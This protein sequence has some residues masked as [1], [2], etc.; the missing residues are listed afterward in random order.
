[1]KELDAQLKQ[2]NEPA[3]LADWLEQ[4]GIESRWLIDGQLGGVMAV[5]TYDVPGAGRRSLVEPV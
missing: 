3:A 2:V 1:M 5:T 4:K